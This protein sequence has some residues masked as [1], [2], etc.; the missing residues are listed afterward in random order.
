MVA[1][2]FRMAVVLEAGGDADAM[3]VLLLSCFGNALLL[4]SSELRSRSPRP[5]VQHDGAFVSS[6]RRTI[7]VTSAP[8]W[9]RTGARVSPIPRVTTIAVES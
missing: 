4:L 2:R 6:Q 7:V 1:G 3:R 5:Q 9:Y 8:A